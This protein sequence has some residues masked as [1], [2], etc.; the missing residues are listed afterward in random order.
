MT[1]QEESVERVKSLQLPADEYVGVFDVDNPYI[2]RY[3]DDDFGD[4]WKVRGYAWTM[5]LYFHRHGAI[6]PPRPAC[7]R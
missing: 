3:S 1:I 4:P 2:V 6:L 7:D 5:P